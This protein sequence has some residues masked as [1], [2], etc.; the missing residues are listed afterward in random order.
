V[1]VTEGVVDVLEAVEVHQHDGDLPSAGVALAQRR[2]GPER[3]QVAV[4]E[5]GE[6]VVECLVLLLR[7]LAAQ[8]FD[9]PG[10]LERGADVVGEGGEDLRVL[11]VEGA[12]IAEAVARREGADDGAAL[13]DR[14]GDHIE[15]LVVA[16]VAAFVRDRSWSAR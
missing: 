10:V 8:P 3:E 11:V 13:E 14:N 9:Q 15:D 1:V 2:L 12:H 7:D 4:A 5:P 6:R 16:E